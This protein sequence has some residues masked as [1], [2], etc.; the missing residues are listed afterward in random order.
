[1]RPRHR[2]A[3]RI[4]DRTLDQGPGRRPGRGRPAGQAARGVDAPRRE[5]C[6]G[7]GREVPLR[8]RLLHRLPGPLPEGPLDRGRDAERPGRG[9]WIHNSISAYR[10]I[11]QRDPELASKIWVQLSPKGPAA[12]RS[13]A[14]CC[15]YGV[16]TF[17]KS[18]DAAKAYLEA[19][20]DS[21]RQGA[22][23]S[24]GYNMPMLREFATPPLPIVSEDPRLKPLEQDAE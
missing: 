18:Q 5:L 22:Q 15:A 20:V 12:R 23:A 1:V 13:F 6:P 19:L 7:Q 21:Y 9:A 3:R 4:R 8:A 17:S 24:T 2:P 10:T 11:E 16:T 14:H